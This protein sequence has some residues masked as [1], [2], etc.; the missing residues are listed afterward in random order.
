MKNFVKFHSIYLFS[1]SYLVDYVTLENDFFLKASEILKIDKSVIENCK[2]TNEYSFQVKN[3]EQIRH[4]LEMYFVNS[5]VR[6]NE[7]V[8]PITNDNVLTLVNTKN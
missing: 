3:R 5:R 2:S 7:L 4:M 1:D 6:Y 8:E